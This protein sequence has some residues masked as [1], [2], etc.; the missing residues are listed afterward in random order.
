[1]TRWPIPGSPGWAL[2]ALLLAC[3]AAVAQRQAVDLEL[4]LAVDVSSSVDA[5]EYELQMSGLAKAFR[6]P[7]VVSAIEASAAGGIAVIVVQWSGTRAQAVAVGWTRIWD[8]DTA[9][10][11]ADRILGV[12]RTITGGSTS[13][14]G[15][16]NF[17]LNEIRNN[18]FDGARLTI[19]ISGDGR[20]NAGPLPATLRDRALAVGVTVNGL[21]ILNDQPFVDTYY[22][23]NVIG[24]PNAFVLPAEDYHDFA[25]AIVEKLVREIGRLL[26]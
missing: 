22:K 1:M 12:P 25:R 3:P 26:S 16:I 11:F 15:A 20:S 7:D 2:V 8:A 23:A 10:R 13:I 19:D 4:V 18:A 21:A 24:G 5:G 9:A 17:A 14:S 6:H